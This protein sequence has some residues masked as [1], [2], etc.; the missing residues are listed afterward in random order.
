LGLA[1][2]RTIIL[3]IP[4]LLVYV[5]M[6][7]PGIV[8]R[9]REW[10]PALPLVLAPL[11][12]YAY[13]PLRAPHTPYLRVELAPGTYVWLYQNDLNSF[14]A[15]VTGST[16]GGSLGLGPDLLD[17]LHQALGWLVAQFPG[18][19]L[20][21]GLW[22][23]IWQAIR[24]RADFT[25][26]GLTFL[27][28][29]CFCLLYRIGD[30]YVLYIPAYLAFAGWLATGAA[31]LL[32]W[33]ASVERRR[34]RWVGLVA[35]GVVLV[36]VPAFSLAGNFSAVD[37]SEDTAARDMWETI[38]TQPLP[39]GAVLVTNDRNEAVPLLYMQHVEGRRPNLTILFPPMFPG[40]QWA[41]V[42]GV[43]Q[44]ALDTGR[45]AYLVKPMPGLEVAYKLVP[46]GPVVQVV[47]P[48]RTD[49]AH[50]LDLSV[51]RSLHLTGCEVT[52]E[53]PQSGQNVAV[54]LAW[55]VVGPAP[56]RLGVTIRLADA[57]GNVVA[58]WDGQPG[59]E[60]YPPSLWKEGQRL[61]VI[62]QLALPTDL[63]PGNYDLRAGFYA[64]PILDP[65]PTPA[66]DIPSLS[67]IAVSP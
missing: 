54:S 11:L 49:L 2:H 59:G 46:A 44:Q 18:P 45:P 24:R 50:S 51:G 53:Q 20:L 61:R 41:D 63:P 62:G 6:A 29:V 7:D 36:S 22:G 43:T 13:I 10:L 55:R 3:L 19:G 39:N 4:A 66:G 12:L 60:F 64:L 52:P 40:P 37:R 27:A 57:N 34:W 1:H 67:T 47:G 56:D 21:L 58:A 30:V 32:S 31:W 48:A 16:F 38:L 17:R 14:L 65:L 5:L 33:L 15:T 9:P 25:L 28:T 35:A 26:L 42:G 8:R 23:A